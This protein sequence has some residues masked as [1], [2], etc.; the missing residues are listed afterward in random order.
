[1][2]C[3]EVGHPPPASP[4]NKNLKIWLCLFFLIFSMTLGITE[5]RKVTDPGF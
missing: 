1:M 3:D 4:P 5:L 2:W